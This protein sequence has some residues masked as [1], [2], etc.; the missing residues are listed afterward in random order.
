MQELIKKLEKLISLAKAIKAPN[1]VAIP[2][3]PKPVVPGAVPVQVAKPSKLP[4]MK[5]STNKNPKKVAEQIKNAE[6]LKQ[7]MPTL[8]SDNEDEADIK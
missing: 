4:G 8:K 2:A 1:A 6:T 5:P 7:N 3:L